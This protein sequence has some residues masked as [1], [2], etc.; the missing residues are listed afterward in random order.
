MHG[1]SPR[2]KFFWGGPSPYVSAHA[3]DPNTVRVYLYICAIE[4]TAVILQSEESEQTSMKTAAWKI[5][6]WH[7][8]DSKFLAHGYA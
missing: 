1:P 5:Q 2:L 6:W 7:S 3:G 8:F 4:L